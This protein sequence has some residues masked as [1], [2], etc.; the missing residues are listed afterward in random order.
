MQY[1]PHSSAPTASRLRLGIACFVLLS[2]ASYFNG[3]TTSRV[4]ADEDR[5]LT[6]R[7]SGVTLPL[8]KDEDAFTFAVF[9]DR[10]G[11]PA[12]GIHVLEQAVADTNLFAPDLVMTVGD[13]IQG[14][15]QTPAWMAQMVQ[16]KLVMS[17]LDM[18]WF[19][20]AGNHD[21]Y[22]R[23][24]GKPEGEHE[25]N[26]EEHF[27]P[28]WYAFEH[29]DCWFVVLYT[30]E[31][32]PKTGERTFH[33]PES[34]S[35]SPEQFAWLQETLKR[36]QDAEHV[37]VFLHHPR[38]IGGGYGSDWDRVHDE[39]AA[40]GNVSAVF[41]GHIHLMRYDGVRDG[42]EYFTLATVGGHTAGDVP[43]AGFLHEFHMVTVRGDDLAVSA[44]PV[45]GV[46]DPREIT[47]EVS[48][49]V[50]KLSKDVRPRAQVDLLFD[51]TQGASFEV[52]MEIT[53][54][55]SRTIEVSS[56]LH[57]TDWRWN[58]G[59]EH[60]HLKIEPGESES[61]T[62][63]LSRPAHTLDDAFAMPELHWQIDYLAEHQRI[64]SPERTAMLELVLTDFPES[65]RPGD[66]P[67]LR[68]GLRFDGNDSLTIPSDRLRLHQGPFTVETWMKASKFNER[69]GLINKT[70]SSEYGFFVNG[71]VPAFMMHTGR[72]YD[73]V[74]ADGPILKVDTWHHIA[75]VYTGTE[76]LLYVDG[77]RIGSRKTRG[78]RRA[79]DLPLIIGADV[80]GSGNPTGHFI[81][82]MDELRVSNIARYTGESFTPTDTYVM[83]EHTVLQLP[84]DGQ[85]G[86]WVRDLSPTGTHPTVKGDPTLFE[87]DR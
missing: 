27:G 6:N 50:R 53:N 20:V 59:T 39:L 75:G 58:T 87:Y 21:I 42:I 49:D 71:G 45:G 86:P 44:V 5:F 17:V 12:A 38:W 10:T 13:L 34:Q 81:G 55:T 66:G 40:A 76:V 11:G 52:P 63:R 3:A 54:P 1:K 80:D 77:Q 82:V 16:F 60:I 74:E 29:E 62:F 79:N 30:D 23:G 78:E 36:T 35:M 33:R 31:G 19:P 69:Q 83:D 48:N 72:G 51:P 15:N 57:S 9:G 18:P 65:A 41:A 25:T 32:D 2:G 37:F 47:A 67:E 28:L 4:L 14:Y 73:A 24:K 8:P 56:W 26:Y 70:E 7:E 22:W 43:D 61:W 85:R 46:L 68:Q 64:S 84:L